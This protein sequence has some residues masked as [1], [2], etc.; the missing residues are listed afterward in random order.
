MQRL[1]LFL[2]TMVLICVFISFAQAETELTLETALVKKQ[3]IPK[4]Y[5]SPGYTAAL[6]KIEISST[7]TGFITQIL[8]EAGDFVEKGQ[9]LLVIDETANM[10]SIEQ[11]KKEIEIAKVTVTDAKKDVDN[12]QR[13]RKVQ[14]ISE[15]K[16]RKARLLLAHSQSTLLKA[17]AKLIETKAATPYLRIKSPEKALVVKRLADTGDLAVSGNPL[18]Y[19]EVLNPVIFETTIPVQWVT[20]LTK[21]Q[22]IKIKLNLSFAGKSDALNTIKGTITQI[23]S[24]ADPIT[25][26]STVKLELPS[27]LNIPTGLFGQAQFIID[28][29]LLLTIPENALV[30]R[31]GITGVFHVD[32]KEQ[33]WF[34]PVR[35]G[36]K[37]NNQR[38]ILSGLKAQDKV[39][40]SPS[41]SLRDGLT[42]SYK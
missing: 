22:T 2:F 40:I 9:L 14:S 21:E 20:K 31:V 42:I 25:Q 34:T 10:Q 13:L 35:Y 11:V 33:I 36:R 39:V 15:E 28:T 5:S 41:E 26:K 19:L 29:E 18:L 1:V 38:V 6:Y 24:S 12:F 32:K 3:L 7:Q 8:V 37:Y 17:R 30:K 23:I 4:Y 16:L 27:T